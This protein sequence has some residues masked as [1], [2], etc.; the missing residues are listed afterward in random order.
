MLKDKLVS[1]KD[2]V[3]QTVK[4]MKN[5]IDNNAYFEDTAKLDD[6]KRALESDSD[7]DK[8][9]SMKRLI[10]VRSFP[11]LLVFVSRSEQLIR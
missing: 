7:K 2:K 3:F 5:N 8:L 1:A 10:A 6:I 4:N 11:F 9:D